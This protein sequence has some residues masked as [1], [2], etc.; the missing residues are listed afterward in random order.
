MGQDDFEGRM[1]MYTPILNLEPQLTCR[2]HHIGC[3]RCRREL[4]GGQVISIHE[5]AVRYAPGYVSTSDNAH[6]LE[7]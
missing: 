4:Y 5:F 2:R 6:Q 7:H 1:E 3:S